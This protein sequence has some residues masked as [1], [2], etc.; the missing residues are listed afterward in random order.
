[1]DCG[2]GVRLQNVAL[3]S[4]LVVAAGLRSHLAGLPGNAGE[5]GALRRIRPP[6][7]GTN[8]LPGTLGRIEGAVSH[9]GGQRPGPSMDR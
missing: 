4:D 9:T 2:P 8:R 1:M 5:A 3:W 6:F 7:P